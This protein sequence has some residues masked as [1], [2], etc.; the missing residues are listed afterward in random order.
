MH[1]SFCFGF[2]SN[3]FIFSFL[4]IRQLLA[5]SLI[6]IN[7]LLEIN[8]S[9]T[10]TSRNTISPKLSSMQAHKFSKLKFL[11]PYRSCHITGYYYYDIHSIIIVHYHRVSKTLI[12]FGVT[13]E[14]NLRS[15]I[16]RQETL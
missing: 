15:F 12:N 14:L 1:L 10:K 16:Q 3:N 8:N 9:Q 6:S 5:F 13:R 4:K 2:I 7:K 11:I